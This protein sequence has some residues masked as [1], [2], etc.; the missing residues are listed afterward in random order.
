[1]PYFSSLAIENRHYSQPCVSIRHHFLLSFRMVLSLASV[2]SHTHADWYSI[3]YSRRTLGRSP[4]SSLC[5]VFS[6]LVV[7]P[8]NSSCLVLPRLSVPS[9]FREFTSLFLSFPSLCSTLETLS[10]K[11]VGQIIWFTLF[12]FPQGSPFF[13]AWYPV[14]W[15][16]FF[17]SV[18]FV[19]FLFCLFLAWG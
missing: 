8:T 3:E 15:K 4:R 9:Q 16:H 7:C 2:S 19:W 10:R 11:Y 1:M 12:P 17:F 6:T 18:Y 5:A 13:I 14:S